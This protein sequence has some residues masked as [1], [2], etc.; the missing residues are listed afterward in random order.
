MSILGKNMSILSNTR[1]S[2]LIAVILI[3]SSCSRSPGHVASEF[4][5]CIE[6]AIR[7]VDSGDSNQSRSTYTYEVSAC[8]ERHVNL[9]D[10]SVWDD[11]NDVMYLWSDK[12]RMDFLSDIGN[13]L[14]ESGYIIDQTRKNSVIID[15]RI[16]IHKN[17][18][19]ADCAEAHVGNSIPLK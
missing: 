7:S 4:D 16:D 13:C 2:A 9:P 14:T 5:Q 6:D 11:D 15:T 18:A 1:R 8:I 12:R 19:V 17:G 10:M 3:V